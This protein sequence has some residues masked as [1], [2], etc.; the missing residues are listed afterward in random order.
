MR[1]GGVCVCVSVCVRRVSV[2][3]CQC[4]TSAVVGG[5]RRAGRAVPLSV[6]GVVPATS[7]LL[8]TVVPDS[9][10]RTP[11]EDG[12]E[13]SVKHKHKHSGQTRSTGLRLRMVH[14]HAGQTQTRRLLSIGPGA[15]F[16]NTTPLSPYHYLFA[17][18]GLRTCRRRGH[19]AAHLAGVSACLTRAG[20]RRSFLS[21]RSRGALLA[22]RR[23][24][25]PSRWPA[26]E[27][28]RDLS[29]GERRRLEVSLR[30]PP[31]PERG[32][33]RLALRRGEGERLRATG[34]ARRGERDRRLETTTTRR[35]YH[36]DPNH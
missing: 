4:R 27:R 12:P 11:P 25:E 30:P 2:C 36:S 13:K 34:E 6:A 17:C 8:L 7:V 10:H 29:G 24:N 14:R 28:G 32:G 5:W 31:P 19:F 3:Q 22:G 20:E 23:S 35:G 26:G 1:P 16:T 15:A 21:D 9:I 18:C 33:E